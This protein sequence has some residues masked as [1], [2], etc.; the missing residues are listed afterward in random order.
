LIPTDEI[1]TW[2]IA[3]KGF[4]TAGLTLRA[5]VRDLVISFSRECC[6][7]RGSEER[8][9]RPDWDAVCAGSWRMMPNLLLCTIN[10][11]A[12]ET[13][14]PHHLD[15]EGAQTRSSEQET[16][17]NSL[18]GYLLQSTLEDQKKR[19]V[20]EKGIPIL[21]YDSAVWRYDA[22]YRVIRFSDYGDRASTY[23]W[24]FD[25]YPIPVAL[26]G[27]DHLSNLRPLHCTNNAGLGG[28]LGN[29]LRG[30]GLGGD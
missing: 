26:G 9:N 7:R 22:F 6:G 20:W 10:I 19:M 14:A 24:E 12:Y 15:H 28:Y 30:R 3:A 21:G 4:E 2:V 18:S 17:V 27:S 23:G 29:A 1:V 11:S 16:A 13:R 8:S 25:H 5:S